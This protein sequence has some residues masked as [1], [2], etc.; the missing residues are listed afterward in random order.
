[1]YLRPSIGLTRRCL[2][3]FASTSRRAF[4][5]QARQTRTPPPPPFSTVPTCPEPTCGCAA[6]PPIPEDLSLDREGPLKGA[7]AGYSEHVLVCTGNADWPSRIEDDNGGDCLAA[8]LKE[9]FGRGGTYSD[10]GTLCSLIW[11]I[12]AN[13]IVAAISQCFCAQL[14]ISKLYTTSC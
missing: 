2:T 6:T 7:I 3:G 10:V 13:L 8:D 9:L 4:A 14:F 12:F 5:Q 11:T 1:M